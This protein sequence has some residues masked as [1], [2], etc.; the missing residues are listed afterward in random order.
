MMD[1]QKLRVAPPRQRNPQLSE[2]VGAT[3]RHDGA[4]AGATLDL[5]ALANK[6]LEHINRNPKR[7]QGATS[8]EKRAQLSP[9][10]TPPKVALSC[11]EESDAEGTAQESPTGLLQ[12][13]EWIGEQCPLVPDDRTFIAGKLSMLPKSGQEFAARRYVKAWLAGADAEPQP[14]R[15]ESAGRF[16]A[17]Q[18]LL[19]VSQR[20]LPSRGGGR[21]QQQST[22]SL[23][24]GE[25][26]AW[27]LRI[28]GKPV[29]MTGR[30]MTKEQALE[31][32]QTRWPGAQV[33]VMP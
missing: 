6:R 26:M 24:P 13:V 17:N 11:T 28:N 18:T 21:V 3:F 5:K 1:H 7:N 23:A 22:V 25:R 27:H 30:P 33:E 19:R 20:P 31:S 9:S 29:V 12:W 32:A 15:K 10:E 4:T 14:V 2:Q 16:A 8:G